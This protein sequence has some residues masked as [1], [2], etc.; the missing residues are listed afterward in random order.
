MLSG[1]GD[2]GQQDQ[3]DEGLGDAVSLGGLLDRSDD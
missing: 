3:T 1:V 2:E